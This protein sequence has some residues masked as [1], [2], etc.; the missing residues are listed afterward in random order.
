MFSI[1]RPT[2]EPVHS[3]RTRE[4]P[5]FLS[6]HCRQHSNN[7][8]SYCRLAIL[9]PKLLSYSKSA[10][11]SAIIRILFYLWRV[12]PFMIFLLLSASKLGLV[13]IMELVRM[14]SGTLLN[15]GIVYIVLY[16]ILAFFSKVVSQTY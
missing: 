13:L 8:G 16:C 9:S 14:V 5:L 4:L 10:S 12:L 15:F 6:P 11:Y 2:S 7:S 3:L 1:Q